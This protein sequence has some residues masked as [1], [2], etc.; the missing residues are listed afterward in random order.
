MP[1]PDSTSYHNKLTLAANVVNWKS[2]DVRNCSSTAIKEI[3]V[4]YVNDLKI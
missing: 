1:L 2:S 4:Y 3:S